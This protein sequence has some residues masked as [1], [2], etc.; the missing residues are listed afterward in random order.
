MNEPE[1]NT[2]E[3]A[4]ES[5]ASEAAPVNIEA[6]ADGDEYIRA[7]KAKGKAPLREVIFDEGTPDARKFYIRKLAAGEVNEVYQGQWRKGKNE[8]EKLFDSL[9]TADRMFIISL[10][11]CVVKPDRTPLWSEGNVTLM[12][13][14]KD[15]EIFA[16]D[17]T[18]LYQAVCEENPILLP[19]RNPTAMKL[20]FGWW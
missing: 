8:E 18:I 7:R 11:K 16:E 17:L 15:A 6:I 5:E 19:S 3:A 4:R 9:A 14:G 12:Y 13:A 20:L 2:E 1:Q 10:Q